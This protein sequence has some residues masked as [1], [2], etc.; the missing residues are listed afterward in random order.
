MKK[1]LLFLVIFLGMINVCLA[2]QQY[3]MKVLL[4]NGDSAI[5]KLSEVENVSFQTITEEK[6]PD[7]V[8]PSTEELAR[9]MKE[10]L[11]G[12][13]VLSMKATMSG[14]DKTLMP[15]GCPT[16][17]K[18]EWS[19]TEE[20]SFTISIL[21]FT[22]GNMGMVLNFKCD[23]KTMA[24]NSW[25]QREYIGNGWIKF[26]GVDGS[27]WGTDTDGSASS[28]SG[29]SVQGYY[30]VKTHEIQF[31]VNYNMM[32]VRFECFRQVVDK[33]RL[34]NYEAEKE[35]YEKDLLEY[36]KEHGIE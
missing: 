36:K 13:I 9:Q 6:E 7:E 18:F 19:E 23:V 31:I 14:V 4:T 17:V 2:Q 24:L 12:D 25:E 1:S 30:N 33:S 16:K 5:Y 3:Q 28:I 29:S 11:T 35:Q 15:S 10:F 27:A 22:I 34:D 26:K 8:V 21:D 20:Q 32:N